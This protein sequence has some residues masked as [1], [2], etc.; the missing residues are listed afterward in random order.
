MASESLHI[1][2][3]NPY[4]S[5]KLNNIFRSLCVAVLYYTNIFK[6][7][8]LKWH[9]TQ[10][11]EKIVYESCKLRNTFSNVC[12]TVATLHNTCGKLCDRLY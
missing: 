10:N 6:L 7:P 12:N 11:F 5:G 4:T 3:T 2:F 8:V 1:T 9:I